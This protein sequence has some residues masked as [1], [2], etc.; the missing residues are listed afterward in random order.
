[1][2]EALAKAC[3]IGYS[4]EDIR[5]VPT[6]ALALSMGC[7]NPTK[8]AHLR[9]GESVLDVGCGAGL[10]SILSSK[11]VGRSGMVLATD[12]SRRMLQLSRR[13]SRMANL[14]NLEFVLCDGENL[15]LADGSVHHIITNCST[16]L[17][18]N[19]QKALEEAYRVVKENG[20]VTFSDI[21]STV[22]LPDE[23]RKD[24]RLWA[25][26]MAGVVTED[27]FLQGLR[28]AGFESVKVVHRRV[29]HY[30]EKDRTRIGKFFGGRTDLLSLVFGL[31]NR[32][33]TL[34]VQARRR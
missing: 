20:C 23:Y 10:D 1:M 34:V 30:G 28:G 33:E 6:E 12:L 17:M 11:Q 16:N 4:A 8:Y 3:S 2:E 32:V 25:A 21:M 31:E 26:C 27:S 19:K 15:P 29:F 5:K 14:T 9:P 24:T 22:V 7:G 18:P 13:N